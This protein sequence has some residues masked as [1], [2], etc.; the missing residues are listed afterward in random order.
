LPRSGGVLEQDAGEMI[1]LEAILDA[2]GRWEE[3]QS[4]KRGTRDK[5]RSR[6]DAV[7]ETETLVDAT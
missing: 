3:Y 2:F 4:K 1:C 7:R 6:H 5:N